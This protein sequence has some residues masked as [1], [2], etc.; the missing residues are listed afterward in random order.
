MKY[1]VCQLTS[2]S[3]IKYLIVLQRGGGVVG[4]LDAGGEAVEYAVASQHRVALR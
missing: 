3:I 1:N 2:K 4:D